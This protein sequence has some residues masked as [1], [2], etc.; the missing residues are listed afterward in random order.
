MLV[1][2]LQ[3]FTDIKLAPDAQ[4]P[5]SHPPPDWAQRSG[6]ESV[7]KIRM[8]SHLTMYAM[9]GLWVRMSERQ[10]EDAQGIVNEN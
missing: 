2:L 10:N 7:E 1:R 4:P 5:A 9:D 8:K 6:R 3:T